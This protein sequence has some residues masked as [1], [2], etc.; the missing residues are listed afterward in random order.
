M[1]I[2][3]RYLIPASS[4]R[5]LTLLECTLALIIVPMAVAAVAVAI[6]TGQSQAAEAMRQTRAAMLAEALMEQVLVQPYDDVQTFCDGFTESPGSV[7]D[8]AGTLCPDAMQSFQR[9]VSCQQQSVTVDELSLTTDGLEITA[10]VTE[11]GVP[12]V[13]L[14]RFVVAPSQDE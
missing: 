8:A 7:T 5:G 12:V 11:N 9:S 2:I 4:R 6:V 10:T 13:T 14:T 1:K 3:G